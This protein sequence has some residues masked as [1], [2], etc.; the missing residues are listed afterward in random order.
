VWG[1][2]VAAVI[3]AGFLAVREVGQ[4]RPAP[5]PVWLEEGFLANPLRK[6]LFGAALL[7]EL[8]GEVGGRTIGEVG[9]GVGV[10]TEELARMA[11]DSGRVLALDRQP[12]AVARARE[13][14]ARAGLANAEVVVGDARRLPWGDATLDCVVM[15]AVLGEVPGFD[16]LRALTE[17]RRVLKPHGRLVVV[18][19]WPDPHYMAPPVLAHLLAAA[20][21]RVEARRARWLQ[22]GMRAC[23]LYVNNCGIVEDGKNPSSILRR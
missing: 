18:E 13:R 2:A 21:F 22:Y 1:L 12:S 3:A 17:V 15:V 5:M 16:R 7:R 4:R 11:G 9:S 6:R 8:L 19:Y 23:R 14:L 20:G 10:M